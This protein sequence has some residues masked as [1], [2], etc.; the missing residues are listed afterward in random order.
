MVAKIRTIDFL[1]DIFKT[2][3][4]SNFLSATLDQLVQQ[5]DL[6]KI[7][8]YVGRR[9][10]YGLT[11]DSYYVPE[12]T[13]TRNN[14][15][16]EPA[17][18][19]KKSDTNKAVDFI[20]YPE[21]LDAL[22][23]EGAPTK[24][25]SLLFENQFYSWD[26]FVN[27]D[28]LSNFSQYYW[29]P[30]GPD[31][32][33]V[34]PLQVNFTSFIDVVSETNNFQFIRDNSYIE[35]LNPTIYLLR[36]G[37]Y[38]FNVN[39]NSK[40]YIQTL[41]GTDGVDPTRNNVTTRDIFGLDFNGISAGTMKFEVPL[42]DA[43][44]N[45]QYQGNVNVDLV[46]TQPFDLI[47][48]QRL[49]SV[50][51]IDNITNLQDKTL[52]FYENSPTSTGKLSTFFDDRGFD[53]TDFDNNV[54]S[55]DQFTEV[56]VNKTFFTIKLIETDTPGDPIISLDV[57]SEIPINT[58]IN[59]LTGFEY[60]NKKFVKTIEG[61][62]EPV[63][64]I[65]APLDTLY[66]QDSQN[67]LKFGEI[68]ILDSS[69]AN[70]IDVEAD[71]LGKVNY[72]SPNK[73]NFVNG[74]KVFFTGNII[75]EFYRNKEYYVEGVGESISLIPT[76]LF[77]SPEKFS[78]SVYNGYDV[79]PYDST[80]F[81]EILNQTV[82]PDYITISR[83]SNCLDAWSRSNK[84]FHSRVLEETIKHTSSPTLQ[85]LMNS[86]S[87]RAR[88]PII[89]FYPNLKLFNS[90]TEFK[91]MVDYFDTTV[92]D[93]FSQVAGKIQYYP[94]GNSFGLFDNCKII[95]SNDS[96]K[97]IKNK[98]YNV[99]FVSLNPELNFQQVVSNASSSNNRLTVQDST[100]F[101][102]GALVSLSEDYG[103]LQKETQYYVYDKP[104]STTIRL[105]DNKNLSSVVT[106]TNDT[107][108]TLITQSPPIIVLSES[109]L[110]EVSYLHQ[111]VILLGETQAGNSYYFDGLDYILAQQKTGINQ[112]PLFD[113][114]DNNN[115]SLSDSDY[116][117]SSNFIGT[118][119]F[120]FGVGTGPDDPI[121][122][123]PLKYSSVNNIGDI[124]FEVTYNLDSFSYLLNGI[125]T[126]QKINLGYPVIFSD[127]VNF[128]KQLG[129][130]TAES[131][132]IQY[133]TFEFN[134]SILDEPIFVCDVVAANQDEIVWPVVKVFIND[135]FLL[136]DEFTFAVDNNTTIVQILIK[137]EIDTKLQILVYSFSVSQS[138]F[139]TIPTNLENNI[140]N[141][142]ISN[143]NLGDIKNQYLSICV[144]SN[145]IQG[146]IFGSNNFNDLP[147]LV[148]FGDKII[149]NSA[150]M[151]LCG[152][153][154]KNRNY[155]LI[156]ALTYNSDEYIKF[157]NLLVDT[158]EKTEYE[159]SATPANILDDV[160]NTISTYKNETNAFFW[161]DM[162]PNRSVYKTSSYT[163]GIDV[164]F[165]TF[166]LSTV[167]DFS[168]AN[169]KGLLIYLRRI[170]DGVSVE[171]QLIKDVDYIVS[172]D[173][174]K[175]NVEL[176]L[177]QNDV[178]IIK[179]YNQT[180]G[181]FVPNTPTKLGFYSKT[182]PEIVFDDSYL[183]PTYFIKGHDG[184]LNVLYGQYVDGQLVDFRDKVLFEFECR[185]YNNLKVANSIPISS[186]E[187]LSG[188]FRNTEYNY[189]EVSNLYSLSFLNWVGKNRIDYKKNYFVQN[190]VY[191]Y[192]YINS[193]NRLDN[194]ILKQGNWRGIYN[195]F[196][197]TVTPNSTPWEMI[198]YSNKPNWWDTYYGSAPYTKNNELLWDDMENGFDYNNGNPVI[199]ES[200]KR[201][202]LKKVLPVDE[203]GNLVDPLNSVIG[204]YDPLTFNSPWKVNDWG[205]A[206]YSYIKSSTWP[207]DLIKILALSKPAK[208]F[209]LCVN[210]DEYKFSTEFNQYLVN[211]KFRLTG[212]NSVIYGSGVAQHSYLNWI[213]D[214]I[215]SSGNVGYD[216]LSSYLNNLDVRLVYRLA[217]FSDKNL[218][219]FYIDKGSPTSKNNSLL[220]PDESY[221]VILHEN[222]P[223]D[224]AIYSSVILQKT[225]NGYAVYGNS[226]NKIYFKTYSPLQN[227]KFITLTS[228]NISVKVSQNFSKKEVIVPY[229]QEFTTLQG[230]AEFLNSYGN[231]LSSQGFLFDQIENN[232]LLNW[233]SMIQEV[234]NWAQSGWEV[235]AILNINPLA[236]RLDFN[237]ENAIVQP[238][239]IQNQN[240]IL[241]QNLI[242]IQIKDLSVIREGTSFTAIPLN[243]DETVAYFTANLSNI[244]HA[245]VFDNT[246]LFNDLI[247][248][249]LTGLRQ[250]RL[251][252]KG[253]KT[254]NW[255]GTVDTKGFILNQDNVTEW[256]SAAK[257]TKGVIVKYKSNY[258]AANNII[259][260]NITFQQGQWTKVDYEE[261]QKGLLP[262]ASSRAYESTLY[263]DVN[264]ANLEN[265]ADLLS[266]SLIGYRPR[267]YLTAAN[268]DDISQ[269]NLYKTMIVEKGS[270]IAT[271]AIDNIK[272]HTG[273]IN[274]EIYENWAIN[275]GSYGGLNNNNFIEFRLEQSKLNNNPN[276]VAVIKDTDEEGASQKIQ[277][278][279]ITN[280]SSKLN[281]TNILPLLTE[282]L[283]TLP[284]AG[285]VNF[286]DVKI[287]GYRITNLDST[288]ISSLYKNEY[289][290]VA[291][292]RNDWRIF[293][294]DFITKKSNVT[295]T[296]VLIVNNFNNSA[297]I[298]F[299][300]E[301]NL[302][303]NDVI[304][305]LNVAENVDGF[306]SVQQV[307]SLNAVVIDLSL[308]TDTIN[309]LTD[310]IFAKC[311]SQ[312]VTTP[313]DVVNLNLKNFLYTST[314]VWVDDD[315]DA[316]WAVLRK[317]LNYI[318]SSISTVPSSL[319]F[320][321]AVGFHPELGYFVSDPL[322]G[323]IYRYVYNEFNNTTILADGIDNGVGYGTNIVIKNNL[324]IVSKTTTTPTS[325]IWIYELVKTEAV[326]GVAPQGNNAANTNPLVTY[327]STTIDKI[328]L[329]DDTNY[330]YLSKS[331]TRQIFVYR[332]NS[333]Y[334]FIAI[335]YT[336][337][338]AIAIGTSSFTVSGDRRTLLTEGQFV[339]FSNTSDSLKYRII[340][341]VYTSG[342]NTTTFVIEGKFTESVSS[343][344]AV[345]RAYLGY[346]SV[347]TIT[348]PGAASG[349][350]LSLAT[351]YDGSKLYVGAPNEDYLAKTDVGA[352]YVYDRVKQVFKQPTNLLLN[353]PWIL[354]LAWTPTNTGTSIRVFLNDVVLSSTQYTLVGNQLIIIVQTKA[355]DIVL[356]ESSDFV[357]TQTLT[358][359]NEVANPRTGML[360]GK[361]LDCT[362][363]GNEFMVGAP[364]D[365]IDETTKEGTVYRYTNEGKSYGIIKALSTY[366]LTSQ[367]NI[368]IN[369]YAV[370]LP[371]SGIDDAI[372]SINNA[373]IPNVVANKTDDNKIIIQL[374]NLNLNA[375][376]DKLNLT[377]FSSTVIN[378]LGIEIYQQTQYLQE[379]NL[380]NST[381]FGTQIKF[382]ELGSV[383][384]TAPA[385]DR[386]LPTYFDFSD[387]ENYLNDTLFDNNFTTFVDI[388][389]DLGS[390]HVYD[391][392][393]AYNENIS[394]TGKFVLAQ[395]INDK[396][397]GY[398]K[399]PYYG[400]A[401]SFNN[402]SI[403]IG[404]PTFT[405]QNNFGKVNL[406]RNNKLQT[407]WHTYRKPYNQVDINKINSIQLYNNLDNL[408]LTSLDYIDPLQG[409]LFGIVR[410]NLD[411][412]SSFDPAG[413]NVDESNKNVVWGKSHLGKLWF[414]T[415]QVKF[416]DYHQNDTLYNSQ[417][418][419]NVFPGS[420]VSIY[421][422]IESE[423]LPLNYSGSGQIYDP[424]LYTTLYE[425]TDT[426]SIIIRYYYWVKNTGIILDTLKTLTDNI[427]S[428][429]ISNPLSSGLSYFAPLKSNV[430]GLYNSND[431]IN[432]NFT[433]IHIGYK[434]SDSE[435]I[436][437]NEYQ[438]IRENNKDDFLP[439]IPTLYNS[440]FTPTSLYKKLLDSFAGVDQ[441]GQEIPN[442]NLP[443]LLQTGTSVRPNQ[444]LF[445]NRFLALQ[446]YCEYANSVM[447]QYPITELKNPSFLSLGGLA[448]TGTNAPAFFLLKGEYFDT[449]KFWNF[450]DWWAEGYS[451]S[452]KTDL[453][454]ERY[455][456]LEKISAYSN[457][458]VGVQ[459]NS[460]NKREVYVYQ[461]NNWQRVGLQNG[462]IQISSKLYNYVEGEFGFGDSFFD[463]TPFDSFPSEE[464]VNIVRGLNEEVF[465]EDLQIH[466]NISL[467]LM[468]NYILN[469]S[470]EFGNYIPWLTKTSFIDVEHT[471]RELVQ[472]KNFQRD[473]EDF[474]FGY[475]NEVKPY[476]VK[477]KEFSLKY[478]KTDL[479]D[480][481][482]SDFDLP[483]QWN[484]EQN[485]FITPELVFGKTENPSQYNADSLIWQ[486]NQYNQWYQN[487]GIKLLPSNNY[488]I[489][490]VAEY[491][492]I[493]TNFIKVNNA[494][495]FPAVGTIKIDKE[496]IGYTS[497][498]KDLGFLFGITRGANNTDI[499]E[500]IP[501]TEIFIDL[502]AVAV[503]DTGRGY[504][505]PPNLITRIDGSDLPTPKIQASL[506]AEMSGDKVIG[507]TVLNPGEGYKVIPEIVVEPSILINFNS[508]NINYKN[509]TINVPI[510]SFITGDLVQYK[511]ENN[512]KP[513]LGLIDKAYYYVRLIEFGINNPVIT[514]LNK[515]S[516]TAIALYLAK[517]DAL[518]DVRRVKLIEDVI[519][520]N[521]SFNISARLLPISSNTPT[522]QITPKLKFDRTSYRPIVTDW[523][524]NQFYINDYNSPGNDASIGNQ[525][526]ESIDFYTVSGPTNNLGTGAIFNV[527]NWVYGGENNPPLVWSDGPQYAIYTAEVNS[528]GIGYQP[529]DIITISGT[530]LGGTSPTNDAVI[531]V[532][533]VN[534]AGAIL[535][536]YVTGRPAV[537][538]PTSLQGAT[539]PIVS[540][541]TDPISSEVSVTVNYNSSTLSPGYIEDK[542]LSFYKVAN[543]TT[544]YIY[545]ASGSGGAV[546][547][548][549]SPRIFGTTVSN[550]YA[551]DIKNYGT[552]YNTNDTITILGT[553]LGGT[554]PANDL[555]ITITYAYLG[556]IIFYKLDGICANSFDKYIVVPTDPT[557][558]KLYKD[559]L[560]LDPVKNTLSNPFIFT[561]SDII[562]APEPFTSLKSASLVAYNNQLWRC[563]VANSDSTFDI[564]KWELL[565]SDY[566]K[567]NALDRIVTY[568]QPTTNMPGK[569][570]PLL[571]SG[572]EYQNDTFKGNKFNENYE[573][574]IELKG[575][576]FY[577]DD[578]NIKTII[579]DGV[580]YIAVGD[581][582]EYSIVLYSNDYVN[583]TWK[584]ISQSPLQVTN[585][586]YSGSY[587]IITTENVSAPILI[588]YDGYS[589]VSA[590]E[591]T[592]FDDGLFDIGGY[593]SLAVSSDNDMLQS[594]SYYNDFFVVVG[595]NVLTSDNAT[596]WQN[597][598][599]FQSRLPNVLKS[600]TFVN[601]TLPT[602]QGFIAV[603]YGL[604]VISDADTAYP[605]IE[606]RARVILGYDGS[607][608]NKVEL[609]IDA[610][611]N[612]VLSSETTI[613]AAGEDAK[614][615]W[616]NNA[617]N[618]FQADI[619][620][621]VNFNIRHGIF[622]KNTF[623]LVGDNGN[624]LY[625]GT[626]QH[627]YTT[628]PITNENL[629]QISFDGNYFVVVGTN[630]TILRSLDLLNWENISLINSLVP[631]YNIKGDDFLSGYGPEELVPA[632]VYDN[633]TMTVKTSP[634]ALWDP[635]TF[636]HFGFKVA[637]AFV[638]LDNN[639]KFSFA[640][641]L[642]YP[643]KLALYVISNSTGRGTRIYET[644]QSAPISGVLRISK[645]D[646]VNKTVQLVG[647]ISASESL[648]VEVYE[649]GS[650]NQR[651]KGTSDSYPLELDIATNRRFINTNYP[652]NGDE[653]TGSTVFINSIK[654]TINVDY[655]IEPNKSNAI[656]IVFLKTINVSSD[657]VSF[658]IFGTAYDFIDY[659]YCIPETQT[660]RYVSGPRT[661]TLSNTI[662]ADN[663]ANSVV[664]IN[665]LR[666]RLTINYTIV[667]NLLTI[668]PL[669]SLPSGAIVSV[670]T[671]NDTLDQS[672]VT[673]TS[674]TLRVTPIYY[675]N[676]PS[677]PVVVTTIINPNLI[678]K[679]AVLIDGVR[680]ISQ[681][682]NN[683][684]Y[685]KPL[686]TYVEN[687]VTF[688][689]FELYLDFDLAYPVIGNTYGPYFDSGIS[690]GGFI[691]KNSTTFTINQPTFDIVDVNRLIVTVN[692]SRVTSNNLRI[693]QPG[694]KLSIMTRIDTGN[695]VTVTSYMPTATPN[696]LWYTM[697]VNRKGE[698]SVYNSNYKNRTWLE[699]PIYFTDKTI[700]V[701]NVNNLVDLTTISLQVIYDSQQAK[702]YNNLNYN[703]KD[704]KEI[705]IRNLTANS[706]V[707]EENFYY[708][709]ENSVTKVIFTG[710]VT[711][712]D[713]LEFTIRFANYILINGEKIGFTAVNYQNNTV[714]GLRRGVDGTA[715]LEV[716]PIYSNVYSLSDKDTLDPFFYN[717]TWNTDNLS[718]NGDPLQLSNSIPANFLKND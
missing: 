343:G 166:T 45:Q 623:V 112:P 236:L 326:E 502:P 325:T 577:P 159:I 98:I 608:W 530:D 81:S 393:P 503:F 311:N 291:D 131:N 173:E 491:I 76:E 461:D 207:F 42:S 143:L 230:I 347:A 466:R 579:F 306:Y 322:V 54:L 708:T 253:S 278:N 381:E 635:N 547:W 464:T 41:P 716:H 372:F 93:A 444:S 24:N 402:Y 285:Y 673:Q 637:N 369:G 625:S 126:V 281:N 551:I 132:S 613:V 89:E 309:L 544:P 475:I 639:L 16:L 319:S 43:Q 69:Q 694:N 668:D 242:P 225:Q 147:N 611:F 566:D 550:Q 674:D 524:P 516:L 399:T 498:N 632:V 408:N 447:A 717:K 390:A 532:Q 307:N 106:L 557:T 216:V 90:G 425:I 672:F 633:L 662:G 472:N 251:L 455:Y 19:I 65:T 453:E 272:L 377:A 364:F 456:D 168:K 312:R 380:Q 696:E 712:N 421:T 395:L 528:G 75:P 169:Y 649:I 252:L 182:I 685:V 36:G 509:Y 599:D 366:N 432:G 494:F 88:R 177:Q 101:Q 206:E 191:T 423:Q 353:D 133:Q 276:I 5:P 260:P 33:Q 305:I 359:N 246:T 480:G 663:I 564:T 698:G 684:F 323:K 179:E 548:V 298:S 25:N 348:G 533:S 186:D 382:N 569:N 199:R 124:S 449:T 3:P 102:I 677:T 361:S 576:K 622:A 527:Y 535:T 518:I 495:G 86:S 428:D 609:L 695:I 669:T 248:D 84:W 605:Q 39:Q 264:S 129:W 573:L 542:E 497:V 221:S 435:E 598:F 484:S 352:T 437:H 208:F 324:M 644:I 422:W 517:K 336:L 200:R 320:G 59:V 434:T 556:E 220:I 283:N 9:Y 240:F 526:A 134:Y 707:D 4:N 521:H 650:G 409:K 316:T 470:D 525:L 286:N 507:V 107:T 701:K 270:R 440:V 537:V 384:I 543:L 606:N 44:E 219:K 11:S 511:K 481:N 374:V 267:N 138:S 614:I 458:I 522:R 404:S 355:G 568:Y 546:I 234:L 371:N 433:S 155:N 50:G 457:M 284:S 391:Y 233:N 279:S 631:V 163:F 567:I 385:A 218:L 110:G 256:S 261:I 187:V 373:N 702:Y 476:R 412:V 31:P 591:Y 487:Y 451:A 490:K 202:G 459:F 104:T 561:A 463:S 17:V 676:T 659:T 61:V 82:Y 620:G 74:I 628:N 130:Q 192:N 545:D 413:Y 496:E 430:F 141:G 205:P 438:L 512:S 238:L 597:S 190:D 271:S 612:T 536:I 565:R 492:P 675:I 410:E 280:Y 360:F 198:G 574:D 362:V 682:N 647:P 288:D 690:G 424:A 47:H 164:F 555:K 376:T 282:N 127:R 32:I 370:T 18:V 259:Q 117:E 590:G 194:T 406:F 392:L 462:T 363:T 683:V 411:Y 237:R 718:V 105:S 35:G 275:L 562:F 624:I 228:G 151:A 346:T 247:F 477:I 513:I 333:S 401:V 585:I 137:P 26:S 602:Y 641:L 172:T 351:N 38:Y 558:L 152:A 201:P 335:G 618:W 358:G 15:Q 40:F 157:K 327:N 467:I 629:N 100:L 118:T 136:A 549:T 146:Q 488:V 178:I 229:G 244:E 540:V 483:A 189:D 8:G 145:L 563:I 642:E 534:F 111:V 378:D 96:N 273:G 87:S 149:Q 709:T 658:V 296:P 482:I 678:L 499:E 560:K 403:V 667:G 584:K 523:Q 601:G 510:S 315:V 443:K 365:I 379:I 95:F 468:F 652:Y 116:Y 539:L 109:P 269:V 439:G 80:E 706:D 277:L 607:R 79:Y 154:L 583:W 680:N 13:K 651:V 20:T 170:I 520:F 334:S 541:I 670:T 114:F 474:L 321:R 357:L 180:Y 63:A 99:N 681:I 407:N 389:F 181:S 83:N 645:I 274:Y 465:T 454:V 656:N 121:L 68:K 679:D 153:L 48:G 197:D 142:E 211:E 445:Y 427:I 209:A 254:A 303:V 589:W 671:F 450:V 452:T 383:V 508:E 34:E 664:E 97:S 575:E 479:Y 621:N 473:N 162:I 318:D 139:Y 77:I 46:T 185:V 570:L 167:Y 368:L 37:V 119:L 70:F 531:S 414:D 23:I 249:P 660:F 203:L 108:N 394:N 224:I 243:G 340:A 214:Y 1:P 317:E 615:Y 375:S 486:K 396:N 572:L 604:Q 345:Y 646:W 648:F 571:L 552:I 582:E 85:N 559:Q 176:D 148:K 553:F 227:G 686:P 405:T 266:F 714:T 30:N 367:A 2:T 128:K 255:E 328:A 293:A 215:Q 514:N 446:N 64:E 158:V 7:Q 338:S 688:Y 21:L 115:L 654:Q 302:Q 630:S 262:N 595:E 415:S 91:G 715:A 188:Q 386:Y 226:Q 426:G 636:E 10:E 287:Y 57:A 354:S 596:S 699:R 594:A 72:L 339:T 419:A 122:G 398:L 174:P 308:P 643:T 263:Y 160:L 617:V 713:M 217:G 292:Y 184:S 67:P 661:F 471:L 529:N 441:L 60:I 222:Q 603:G 175:V 610:K 505:E 416:V 538:Y 442:P 49:S 342:N 485:S 356:V 66:Y 638:S 92:T 231:Y 448:L 295:A 341:G 500:H 506:R 493:A 691:W 120:Q 265:D 210:L 223:F 299:N 161:S 183:Y 400:Y 469:E 655:I 515:N 310:G 387:D 478:S 653:Y 330:L 420:T 418:W 501:G 14:Y 94:D 156:E 388:M 300:N 626:G 504:T 616:T 519:T 592:V 301:H 51:S 289:I 703:I 56:F 125:S 593:D 710:G 489:G 113:I 666:Q 417:Y 697:V 58:N 665:G 103:G 195:W 213:V 689:P 52:L 329:S 144:N 587:Y 204:N 640:N 290:W 123:F 29:L 581:T 294:L 232:V 331:S 687:A 258:Y 578:I 257:Y 350:G 6:E 627:W 55:Y 436:L 313:A 586:V 241:N 212:Q 53:S 22:K 693:N 711:V 62:I 235:G 349:F 12:I 634:G 657:F 554:S 397:L 268:L 193:T 196:F 245:I 332:K 304:F 171:R 600:V 314:T 337:S 429:Y 297:T 580:K 165:S 73:V 27:L 28:K 239:T 705:N 704:I 150:P 71:I 140:F 700:Y 250:Y 431:F 460:N 135:R 78:L 619:Y 692:G 344:N 588:S